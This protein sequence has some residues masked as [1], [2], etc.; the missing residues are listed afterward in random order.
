MS[1]WKVADRLD[2]TSH[3]THSVTVTVLKGDRHGN[4]S[5]LWLRP[6]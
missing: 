6:D 5:E 2:L 3:H 1:A 4:L